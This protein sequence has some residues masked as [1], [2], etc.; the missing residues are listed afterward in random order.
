MK[1]IFEIEW[2]DTNSFQRHQSGKLLADLKYYSGF[3]SIKVKELPSQEE[4]EY[5]HCEIPKVCTFGECK[6]HRNH[7]CYGCELPTS[8]PSE[9][10]Y[11][12]GNYY[13]VDIG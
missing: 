10:K 11:C 13:V 8:P 3:K 2:D 4:K 12:N 9:K 6:A 5:C 1:K 7:F